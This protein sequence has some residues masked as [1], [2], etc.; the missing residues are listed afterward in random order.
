MENKHDA[1]KKL[2]IN[3]EINS[4]IEKYVKTNDNE[5]TTIRNLWDYTKTVLRGKFIAVEAYTT[6]QNLYNSTKKLPRR[7]FTAIEAFLRKE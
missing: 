5:Y 7:K 2:M 1:T 3:E 6:I 4:E